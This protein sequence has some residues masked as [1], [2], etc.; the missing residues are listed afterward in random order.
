MNSGYALSSE[1]WTHF[2]TQHWEKAPLLLKQPFTRPF[3]TPAEVFQAIVKASHHFSTVDASIPVRFFIEDTLLQAGAQIKKHIPVAG[4]HSTAGYAE[5]MSQILKERQFA[6]VI[7]QIQEH[8]AEFWLR[9][10]EFLRGL[11]AFIGIPAQHSYTDVFI[12]NY[13][14]T[15]FG[16]HQDTASN[17]MFIIEGQKRMRLWPDDFFPHQPGINETLEYEQFLDGATTLE[18]GPGDVIYWPSSYWHVGESVG[19]LTVSLNVS[20][21]LK[22]RASEDAFSHLKRIVSGQLGN[23]DLAYVYPFDPKNLQAS[24]EAIPREMKSATQM[25]RRVVKG[26]DFQQVMKVAWMNRV[27]GFGFS[28]VP[29]PLPEKALLDAC[30]IRGNPDY[31]IV[32][33]PGGNHKITYSANG[34]SFTLP[35]HPSI[36]NL[37]ERLNTGAALQVKSLIE[38]YAGMIEVDGVEFEA[39]REGIR[40]ILEKLYCLRAIT[41]YH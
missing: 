7:N 16:V 37:V 32:W 21:W 14:T 11:Y 1:F 35:A 34:H 36:L 41:D 23:S 5:R 13:T 24:A 9:A 17:F 33:M 39:D 10:R 2:T 4:D 38:E 28:R 15:P 6:L 29:P 19:G 40:A 25:L 20:L 3:A 27:T 30:F 12:G 31:P 8:E 26:S 18:G 22:W